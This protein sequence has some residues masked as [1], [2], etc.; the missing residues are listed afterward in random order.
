MAQL[1]VAKLVIVLLVMAPVASI[2]PY[3]PVIINLTRTGFDPIRG[4]H[5]LNLYR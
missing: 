5:G 3:E 2:P 1:P 4:N